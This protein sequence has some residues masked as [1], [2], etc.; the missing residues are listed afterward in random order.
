MFYHFNTLCADKNIGKYYNQCCNIIPHDDDW[1]G[2]W[3]AD[4]LGFFTVTNYAEFLEKSIIKYPEVKL[5]TCVTNRIGTHKQRVNREQ[6]TNPSMKYHRNIAA[7]RF[8]EFH[9]TI[10]TNLRTCSGFFMLFQKSTWKAVGGFPEK[11]MTGIDTEFTRAIT[12]NGWKIGVLD[13]MYL[14]HYYRLFENNHD[15]LI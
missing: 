8:K 9:F 13:G 4:I 15:H 11:Q 12:N 6:D 14:M 7:K 10:R 2:I 1:I 5:F 3:D